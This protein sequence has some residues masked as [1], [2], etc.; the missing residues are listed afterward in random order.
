MTPTKT[1]VQVDFNPPAGKR[2]A[3]EVMSIKDLKSRASQDHFTRLQR[4]DFY[5]LFGVF[6]GSTCPMID[7]SHHQAQAG[8]WILVRPGQVMRYD[9]SRPWTGGLLV[10]RPD[11][12][13]GHTP[14]SRVDEPGLIQYVEDLASKRSLDA[15]QHQWMRQSLSQMQQDST[16]VLNPALRNEILRTQLTS[17]LLRLSLWQ[18]LDAGTPLGESRARLN[19]RRFLRAL[20]NDFM[21]QHQVQYYA[22]VL[23]MSEKSLG[24]VCTGA[25]GLSA[26]ACISQRLTLEAKR[27]LAHTTLAVHAVG[28]ELGFGEATNFVKFFRKEVGL[29]PLNFRIA[30]NNEGVLGGAAASAAKKAATRRSRVLQSPAPPWPP[31]TA[32]GAGVAPPA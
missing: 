2:L 3:V 19:F 17:T 18:S 20:D 29:T 15:E 4:A 24:R 5:R 31:A 22:N 27:L 25:V 1:I 6:S 21:Q 12:L 28:Q 9:F 13:F 7:F 30:N 16:R 26:K 8:D 14:Q 32:T 11:A 23:G 10:F